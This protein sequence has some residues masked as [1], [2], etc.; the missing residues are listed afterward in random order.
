MGNG[1]DYCSFTPTEFQNNILFVLFMQ[2]NP[3]WWFD[4]RVWMAWGP[5]HNDNFLSC[6]AQWPVISTWY[7][8]RGGILKGEAAAT[9]FYSFHFG[10]QTVKYSAT[11]TVFQ[12]SL[13]RLPSP[14]TLAF[15]TQ[16]FFPKPRLVIAVV[17][18]GNVACSIPLLPYDTLKMY[19]LLRN[20]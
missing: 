20:R 11:R 4:S 17:M 7:A 10:R 2:T 15:T 16:E 8:Q 9:A 12:M 6:V 14:R 3:L 18:G 13:L 5:Y 1:T 19:L